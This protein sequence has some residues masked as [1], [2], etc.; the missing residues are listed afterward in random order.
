MAKTQEELDRDVKVK[1]E[2]FLRYYADLPVQK[3]AAMYVDR[4]EHA[5]LRWI[6]NDPEFAAKMKELKADWVQRKARKVKAEFALE[7][8][9]K[10]IWSQKTETEHSGTFSFK[11]KDRNDKS[12]DND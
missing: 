3:Y 4:E 7:R 12:D 5:V 8:L 6:K 1:K 9:E 11:W 2:M 10:D